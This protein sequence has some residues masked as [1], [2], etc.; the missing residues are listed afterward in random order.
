[1]ANGGE[2]SVSQLSAGVRNIVKS[3]G[4]VVDGKVSSEVLQKLL[5]EIGQSSVYSVELKDEAQKV[6]AN[7]NNGTL[8]SLNGNAN[9]GNF[10]QLDFSSGVTAHT[11]LDTVDVKKGGEAESSPTFIGKIGKV[12]KTFKNESMQRLGIPTDA[13]MSDTYNE[14]N[15]RIY[16]LEEQFLND[17]A[18]YIKTELFMYSEKGDVAM[19]NDLNER[20]QKVEELKVRHSNLLYS[21]GDVKRL[22]ISEMENLTNEIRPIMY[23]Y[24][25]V[26]IRKSQERKINNNKANLDDIQNLLKEMLN[27]S[28]NIN[29][30]NQ[31]IEINNNANL[32]DIQNSLEETLN[33]SDKTNQEIKINNNA[34]LDD[35]QNSLKEMLNTSE[36][37]NKMNQ[38]IEINN[39]ANLDDIQNS[40]EEMLNV[41][42]KTNQEKHLHK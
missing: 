7:L 17:I 39:N 1:M 5:M 36:N 14:L 16:S 25:D 10:D 21:D 28:E 15:S 30:M 29:K 38:E 31:E 32:D 2:I 4:V 40:L 19:V 27:T 35:I 8:Q 23:E 18:D 13:E 22:K 11:A 3:K 9:W 24:N 6:L 26:L 20:L 42:D 34:N 12:I 41:S 37:I 33:V